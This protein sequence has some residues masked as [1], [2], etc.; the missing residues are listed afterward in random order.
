MGTNM[1]MTKVK[2]VISKIDDFFFQGRVKAF[3]SRYLAYR[4]KAYMLNKDLYFPS[5]T[6][7]N[8][9]VRLGPAGELLAIGGDL[10]PERMVYAF[11]KGI[12]QISFRDQPILWWTSEIRCVFYP[13]NLHISK[14]MYEVIKSNKFHLSVDKAFNDVV[15]AC[16]DSR[17]EFT[18]LTPERMTSSFQLHELGYAHSIEVWQDEKLV[19]GLFGIAF[20][21]YFY[22]ES[23]FTRVNHTSKLALIALTIRLGEMDFP[24]VDFGI[25]PTEHAASLGAVNISR[26]KF[27]ETLDQSA[28]THDIVKDWGVLFENWD[29]RSA[30]KYH[31]NEMQK[32]AGSPMNRG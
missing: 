28:Q 5:H 30:V 10:S 16:S 6:S 19:G 26:D 7:S 11:K 31:V 24:M 29:F 8:K 21:S 4:G 9:N 32:N 3:Y 22:I 18:W 17:K 27:L 13:Q 25:W 14:K 12:Y 20:G 1:T 23:M 2:L 15:N